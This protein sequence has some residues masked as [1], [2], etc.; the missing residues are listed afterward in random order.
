MSTSAHPSSMHI[1]WYHSETPDSYYGW[2]VSYSGNY[3]DVHPFSTPEARARYLSD[4]TSAVKN[5]NLSD[6]PDIELIA[7]IVA[8]GSADGHAAL[9]DI[10]PAAIVAVQDVWRNHQ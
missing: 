6:D 7:A 5:L 1:H 10:D 4:A 3:D 8:H 2:T 9:E